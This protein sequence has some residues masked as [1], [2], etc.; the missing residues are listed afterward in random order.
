MEIWKDI[1]GFKDY[2]VSNLGNVKSFKRGRGRL[3]KPSKSTGYY[4]VIL[5]RDNIKEGR[6]IHQL[7]AIAFLGY[8]TG[9]RSL[10]VDHINDIKTDNRL[11]NLQ[12]I[13]QRN[14]A[15]KTQGRY[16]SK[17]KGVT[18][19]KISNKWL[20]QISVNNKRISLGLRDSEKEAHLLYQKA[21]IKYGL[22]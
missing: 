3:L 9:N 15:Y 11:D 14:N 20:A 4:T 6:Y 2:Q 19:H 13:T 16:S 7:M 22:E 1:K 10:V 17:F 8:K 21:L 12:V 18:W 5:S